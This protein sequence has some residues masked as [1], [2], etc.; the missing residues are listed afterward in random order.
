[1]RVKK[2][3][4]NV[5]IENVTCKA[6]GSEIEYHQNE[7]REHGSW[8]RVGMEESE[9]NGYK[10]ITCPICKC[11]IIINQTKGIY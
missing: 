6:C 3:G 8:T 7:V 10:Y 11:N 4:T 2:I 1:M 9:W 5:K